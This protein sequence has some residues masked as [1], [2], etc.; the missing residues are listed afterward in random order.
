M[1]A[2]SQRE[3]IGKQPDGDAGKRMGTLGSLVRTIRIFTPRGSL[4]E[5]ARRA[6]WRPEVALRRGRGCPA[7]RFPA[8]SSS[9]AGVR[10]NISPSRGFLDASGRIFA[11]VLAAAHKCPGLDRVSWRS[12]RGSSA[13]YLRVPATGGIGAMTADVLFLLAVENRQQFVP[14]SEPSAEPASSDGRV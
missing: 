2:A 4:A 11:R 13:H 6:D 3:A 12:G 14:E 5:R 1:N 7:S 8:G 10:L 9:R